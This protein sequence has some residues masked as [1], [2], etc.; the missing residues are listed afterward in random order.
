MS[1][2]ESSLGR[3]EFSREELSYRWFQKQGL[4]EDLVIKFEGDT[5]AAADFLA[6]RESEAEFSLSFTPSQYQ[7][8]R[9]MFG[10]VDRGGAG[11]ADDLGSEARQDVVRK[12][13]EVVFNLLSPDGKLAKLPFDEKQLKKLA[14]LFPGETYCF[15]EQLSLREEC[16]G[17]GAKELLSSTERWEQ[18]SAF[19]RLKDP[20][21]WQELE[22]DLNSIFDNE[23]TFCQFMQSGALEGKYHQL[24]QQLHDR[25]YIHY[26]RSL[27]EQGEVEPLTTRERVIQ[28]FY[29][30]APDPI[31]GLLLAKF[32]Q[33]F[34]PF[35]KEFQGVV[36]KT[37][38]SWEKQGILRGTLRPLL[39]TTARLTPDRQEKVLTAL[40]GYL[41]SR[42]SETH[43]GTLQAFLG[44]TIKSLASKEVSLVFPVIRA[45]SLLQ[46]FSGLSSLQN[47]TSKN[48]DAEELLKVVENEVF[49]PSLIGAVYQPVSLFWNRHFENHVSKE[50]VIESLDRFITVFLG[51][52]VAEINPSFKTYFKERVL[53]KIRSHFQEIAFFYPEIDFF[54]KE[55]PL[56]RPK[57]L[58]LHQVEGIKRMIEQEG[59][60]LADEPGTGKTLILALAGLNLIERK[61]ERKDSPGRILVVGNKSVIDNWEHEINKHLLTAKLETINVNTPPEESSGERLGEDKRLIHRLHAVNRCL[62]RPSAEK[63]IC[64]VNYDLFRN[65]YF[66]RILS[67]HPFDV[68]IVD[69]VHHVK[70][71]D[72]SL[73]KT[74]IGESVAEGQ[75]V[76]KRTRGLYRFVRGHPEMAVFLATSTPYVKEMAEPLVLANLVAPGKFDYEKIAELQFR[77]EATHAAL[78]EVMIRRRKVEVA[79]LPPKETRFLPISLNRLSNEEREAFEVAA[80]GLL[81]RTGDNYF[82]RFYALLSL[83]SQVKLSWL[84][85]KVE[86]LLHQG[87]KVLIFTPFVYDENRYSAPMSTVNLVRFLRREGVERVGVLDGSLDLVHRD[88]IQ[89]QFKLPLSDQQ[90]LDVLVGNYQTAGES[91]TLCSPSNRATEV[92]LFVCPNSVSNLVQAVDRVHRFGQ[93]EAVTI[94]VPFVTEDILGRERGTYDERVVQRLFLELSWFNQV[95]D[96]LFFIE[97]PDIYQRVARE[98]SLEPSF[99]FA[100][101]EILRLTRKEIK[102]DRGVVDWE[103]ELEVIVSQEEE[104][105]Q[106]TIHQYLKEI[107]QY[108]LLS[109]EEEV[110]LLQK[111][112][113][114]RRAARILEAKADDSR[115]TPKLAAR[116]AERIDEG[117][118]AKAA[119]VKANLRLV[120]YVAK[121]YQG[122][123]L[124]LL[125]LIQE[126]TLG[127]MKATEKYDWQKGF[128]FSTYAYRGIRW[129]ITRG[130]AN[131]STTIRIPVYMRRLISKAEKVSEELYANTGRRPKD[132]ELREILVREFEITPRSAQSVI[133]TLRQGLTNVPSLDQYISDEEEE[134]RGDFVVDPQAQTAE[135]VERRIK[136]RKLEQEVA[137]ILEK[138]LS[139]REKWIITSRHLTSDEGRT[140]RE[141]GEELGLTRERIRQIE[142]VA[143]DRLEKSRDLRRLW[144]E[145]ILGKRRY[146]QFS[147]EGRDPVE[148]IL[149]ERWRYRH[150]SSLEEAIFS[151]SRQQAI[152]AYRRLY[153]SLSNQEIAKEL[154]LEEE[155]VRTHFDEA[156]IAL[157]ERLPMRES[158]DDS[159]SGLRL[160]SFPILDPKALEEKYRLNGHQLGQKTREVLEKFFGFNGQKGLFNLGDT[161]FQTGLTETQAKHWL[162]RGLEA[163]ETIPVDKLR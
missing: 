159:F 115:M 8:A 97:P 150:L 91:I 125:D 117:K 18:G 7:A 140:L 118:K 44:Q 156:R 4:L 37:L 149:G 112:Q 30:E 120:V 76:A 59:G 145:D 105:L 90:S 25:F 93:A 109:F 9:A 46:E 41:Y 132:E 101:G 152:I 121:K 22:R 11:E 114:G 73:A 32:S 75:D 154:N 98:E 17:M 57:F 21:F 85:A 161:A 107:G 80:Q 31:K 67:E 158:L 38:A 43:P 42:Q 39:Q 49:I 71:R 66:Q 3:G 70:S 133:K 13:I 103:E 27:R 148:V 104:G 81:E 116:L 139:E 100:P 34:N 47:E 131:F 82:A 56:G 14:F 89:R 87:K 155:N 99:T 95:I 35:Q 50:A 160:I 68:L 147:L 12:K 126:G 134:T 84:K 64:L 2:R 108:P 113:A 36:E 5:K 69:E 86:I 124:P 1:E 48:P 53:P 28:L 144:F 110:A 102:R 55:D 65:P 61:G 24:Y 130:L 135:E 151:L 29:Q 123:G 78:K 10:L 45:E 16:Q 127:L 83:E 141:V 96:G 157:W 6:A 60:I 74:S 62:L 23:R 153:I 136:E 142:A 106:N 122:Q 111:V 33:D 52:R 20:E 54:L 63:Q 19:E 162:L 26:Y 92:I 143:F 77:P 58:F 15:Y 163:L 88:K 94:H 129:S 72:I 128:K 146:L 138:V 79:D 40:A 137:R 119:L 51:V